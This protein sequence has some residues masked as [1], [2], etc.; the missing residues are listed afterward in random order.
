VLNLRES[1][2]QLV[3]DPFCDEYAVGRTPN[4]CIRCNTF[5]KFGPL[6]R[7]AAEIQAETLATG[8]YARTEY[9]KGS[10]RWRLLRGVDEAKDQSYSLYGLSQEHLSR[11]A[12][13]LGEMT[14]HEVRSRASGLGLPSA[15]RQESQ[16]V[17]F[18][19]DGSYQEYLER[20]RPE[21]VQPGPIVD[22]NGRQL[23][24]HRGIAF[25]TIGQR[26]G[27]RVSHGTSLYVIDIDLKGNR[28]IVGEAAEA[29]GRG[30]LMGEVNLVSVA[31]LPRDESEM[32]VK[33][34]SG[35]EPVACR[36]RPEREGV[37][38]EF[39]DRQ[40][41]VSPGQAAVCYEEDTV[42]FG[43]IIEAGF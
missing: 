35:G 15:D 3:I 33:I 23:G 20:E 17:C 8:H 12:F 36:V 5:V 31:G 29:R 43:G 38:V 10:S 40:W 26:Q 27:L 34:R 13:P 37:R 11:A 18:V 2:R 28:L 14:K 30:L 19:A 1:F 7:R 4:P 24:R 16:D 42:A 21:L 41:A 25:Y 39:A 6:L 32:T 22:S 9:D